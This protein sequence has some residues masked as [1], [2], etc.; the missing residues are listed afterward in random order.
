MKPL[1]HF[2]TSPLRHFATS[3]LRH[4]SQLVALVLLA[5]A[6]TTANAA[7][8]VNVEGVRGSG[9]TT[10]TLSGSDK[11]YLVGIIRTGTGSNSFSLND[12]LEPL[13]NRQFLSTT[14]TV[15]ENSLFAVTGSAQITV[16]SQTR[17]ITHLFLDPDQ[18]DSGDDFG[19]RVNSLLRYSSG[20]NSSWTG[21]FTLDLDIGN[22]NPGTYR[23]QS[24]RF[25][26]FGFSQSATL[27][28][29][30]TASVPKPSSLALLGLALASL[31]VSRKRKGAT[32]TA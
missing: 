21:R 23:S 7:L 30:E 16:G 18:G 6:C 15:G 19:I 17:T 5:L 1:R 26:S 25:N 27:I 3:P 12:T 9:K 13:G 14:T 29:K 31:G 20:E 28:F 2:A 24:S 32:S 8:I 10:W 11:A 4:A 22:F